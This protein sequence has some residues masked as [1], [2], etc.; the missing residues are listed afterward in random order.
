MTE[1]QINYFIQK[2]NTL[3]E[4]ATIIIQNQIPVEMMKVYII[5]GIMVLLFLMCTLFTIYSIRRKINGSCFD[6][7]EVGI[8]FGA[9]GAVCFLCFIIVGIMDIVQ[10]N[11]NPMYY[12]I[13]QI[14][15]I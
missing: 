13:K 15:N 11:M 12:M 4:Q 10:L 8:I 5:I 2:L 7:W 3:G 14:K 1:K 9:I 6:C